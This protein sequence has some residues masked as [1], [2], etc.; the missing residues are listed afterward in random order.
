[1]KTKEK[2]SIYPSASKG[3]LSSDHD[4]YI[5]PALAKGPKNGDMQTK[6]MIF[7]VVFFMI[8]MVVFAFLMG[9]GR[10]LKD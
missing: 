9:F 1:M 10:Y 5:H 2:S 3:S 8:F 4:K 6:A 7:G